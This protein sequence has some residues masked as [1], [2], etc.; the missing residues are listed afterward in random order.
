MNED[1]RWGWDA[2]GIARV[3]KRFGG[4]AEMFEAHG[5]REPNPSR[6]MTSSPQRICAMYGSVEA[7]VRIVDAIKAGQLTKGRGA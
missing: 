5:W 7:F 3:A 4:Y 6:L 2:Q 1:R